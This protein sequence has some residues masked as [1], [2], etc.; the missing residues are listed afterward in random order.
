[1]YMYVERCAPCAMKRILKIHWAQFICR[2]IITISYCV[3]SII[4]DLYCRVYVLFFS[5]FLSADP[6]YSRRKSLDLTVAAVLISSLLPFVFQSR[7]PINYAIITI[8]FITRTYYYFK[9]LLRAAYILFFSICFFC[10]PILISR[11]KSLNLIVRCRR[12]NLESYFVL[13]LHF[14]HAFLLPR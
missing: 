4:L 3:H 11:R 14:N 1:M 2:A 8:F 5:T 9:S 10:P 7:I 13:Y 12:S 6:Y